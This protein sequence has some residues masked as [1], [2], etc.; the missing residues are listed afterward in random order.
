VPGH[1]HHAPDELAQTAKL[2]GFEAYPAA[3]V[4]GALARIAAGD[5]DNA[6]PM[7]L[8]GGSLYLAGRTLAANGTVID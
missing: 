5:D 3:S 1:D 4:E 7:V 8:V 2:A 6:P